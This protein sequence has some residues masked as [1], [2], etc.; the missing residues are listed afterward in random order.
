MTKAEKRKKIEEMVLTTMSKID[1][2]M[3]NT[4]KYRVFFKSM[5]TI[6][7]FE[8]WINKFLKDDTLNLYME[9]LPYKNEPVLDNL[10]KA[11]KY[12]NVPLDEYIYLKHDGNKNNPIR[13]PYKVPVGYVM[14]KRLQQ[15][16]MKKN[17]F[18]LEIDQRNQ[19]TNQLTGD[20]K[21]ARISDLETFSLQAYEA[22]EALK[23]FF[24]PRGDDDVAK[25]EM[26][27]TISTQGYVRQSDLTNDVKNKRTLNTVDCYFLGAGLK[28]DLVT[29]DLK[30]LRTKD[31]DKE[32]VSKKDKIDD[33]IDNK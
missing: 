4:D 25:T 7:D 17:S 22:D 24:G 30:L 23:E 32:R 1:P 21:I 27:K 3:I 9:F 33:R 12:L 13:T 29:N 14:I 18:S 26:Y 5:K 28:T 2:T 15:M 8:K 20:D 31:G 6:E 16:L 19:K 10:Y 11:G